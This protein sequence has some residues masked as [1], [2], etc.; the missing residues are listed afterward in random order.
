MRE[1]ADDPPKKW[2]KKRRREYFD[3]AETVVDG[4]GAVNPDLEELFQETLT[5]ARASLS[6]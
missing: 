1:I 4:M 6:D 5:R 3:W 2:K